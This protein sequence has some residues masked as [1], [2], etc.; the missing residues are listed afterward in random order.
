MGIQEEKH[1]EEQDSPPSLSPRSSLDVGEAGVSNGSDL[2]ARAFLQQPQRSQSHQ[3]P[4]KPSRAST[5]F[6]LLLQTTVSLLSL[7]VLFAGYDLFRAA[8]TPTPKPATHPCGTEAKTA[9]GLK[10]MFDPI[11]VAWLPAECHDFALTGEFMA[12]QKWHYWAEAEGGETLSL[13]NVMQGQ[14]GVLYVEEE[15]VRQR[16]VF[17]WRKLHGAVVNGTAVD[18]YTVDW[19]GLMECEEVFRGRRGDGGRREVKVRYPSCT[20]MEM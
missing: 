10:C 4:R 11:A 19:E 7:G 9:R 3:P 17:A 1:H 20:K 16:C 8:S 5:I 14:H 6:L 18:G 13:A 12:V 2:E 15:Y